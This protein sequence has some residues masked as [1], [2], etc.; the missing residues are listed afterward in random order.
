[1]KKALVI[2]AALSGS[3]VSK[4]LNKKGYE[5][6]LT[7]VKEIKEKEDL[8]KLGIKVFDNGH[9]DLLKELKYDL[10]VKNPGIKY[11]NPFIKYFSD[12]GYILLNEIEVASKFVNYKYGAITGTNGK[13]TT[14]TLLGKMLKKQYK[15]KA[16]V[17]G[18]IGYPLSSIVL[19]HENEECYI[20]LEISGFQLLACPTFKPNVATILNLTPDH[21]DYY[22]TLN[23]YYDSKVLITNNLDNNCSFLRFVDDN[24]IL[25]RTS[26]LNT[27]VIDYSLNSK[28][29]L[30]VD[31]KG[32]V[33]FKD[34]Y[35]FSKS[36]LNIVGDHNLLN[37]MVASLNAYLLGVSVDNIKSA[38]KEFNGVEHRIE[39]VKEINGVKFY[40]DSKAT[41]VDSGIV[42]LKSFNQQVI[43][44]AG[45]HD[46]HTGFNEIVPY[47]DKVKKMYVFGETKKQLKDIYKDAI[48]CENMEEAIKRAYKESS[49]QDI[50]LLSPLCSSYDQFKNFEDR[51]NK[52]KEFVNK[53]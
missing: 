22:N 47:L 9:P 36:D 32:D 11:D 16:F 33:Y 18:N 23:D 38:I 10:I 40:N 30:Y 48:L 31:D 6:Y 5:V 14:V 42:A 53:L 3:A 29:D 20:A 27:N 51:G 13:T 35:L 25:K 21:L 45:G 34:I 44:L 15:D 24:E 8:I 46:K 7:D 41:N 26:S 12:M 50:I 49:N 39:F 43:L 19:E 2:G 37:V 4:L 28:K 17:S 1:M 52:F